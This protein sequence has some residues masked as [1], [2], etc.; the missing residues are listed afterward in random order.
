MIRF[1]IVHYYII[2]LL[3]SVTVWSHLLLFPYLDGRFPT[4][5]YERVLQLYS[6]IISYLSTLKLFDDKTC[7]ITTKE[8]FIFG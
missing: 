2:P 3:L 5:L 7:P 1:V 6:S 4:V 8:G